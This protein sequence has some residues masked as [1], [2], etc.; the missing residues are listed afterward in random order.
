VQHQQVSGDFFFVAPEFFTRDGILVASVCQE[1][2]IRVNNEN[3]P[4]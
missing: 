2:L 4:A 3:N 1:G